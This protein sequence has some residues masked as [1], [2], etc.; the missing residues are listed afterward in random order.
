VGCWWPWDIDL[1]FAVIDLHVDN[2][3]AHLLFSRGSRGLLMGK[4]AII[5]IQ[6]FNFKVGFLPTIQKEALAD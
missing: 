1:R 5:S 6:I 3:F 4:V 2:S